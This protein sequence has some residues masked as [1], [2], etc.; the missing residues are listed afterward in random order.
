MDRG[1]AGTVFARREGVVLRRIADEHLLIPIRHDVAD[2]QAIYAVMGVGVRIW[3]LLD[4]RR[5][6]NEIR[7]S[8]VER[9]AVSDEAAWA[10]LCAFVDHLE[11]RG[12]VERL[13]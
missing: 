1:T 13:P 10:D 3:E 11:E 6:L 7:D 8:I 12:L 2:I 5:T 4:G 9:H